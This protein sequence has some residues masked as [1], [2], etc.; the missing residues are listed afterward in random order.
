MHP[1]ILTPAQRTS[2]A[3]S[4]LPEDMRVLLTDL[5]EE[6]GARVPPTLP[7]RVAPL[8][9]F[10]AAPLV[11]THGDSRDA[12]YVSAM[13]GQALPPLIATSGMLLDGRHRLAAMRASGAATAE[14]IDLTGLIPVPVVP[15][16]GAIAEDVTQTPQFR[17]WFGQSKVLDAE[18]KPLVVHHGTPALFEAFDFSKAGDKAHW[19]VADREHAASFGT[20]QAYYLSIANPLEISQ[21]DLDRMWDLENDPE[22]DDSEDW[23][24][25]RHYVIHFVEQA[26]KD[27][28]DGLLIRSMEDR[29]GEFDMYLAFEPEQIKSAT[30]NRGDFDP[31]DPR[32]AFKRAA[33]V[34][35][36]DEEEALCTPKF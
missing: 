26:R 7:L 21:A 20:P 12:A 30:R 25:P 2:I 31:A 5:I 8:S 6:G 13:Q 24:L 10:P 18:G 17:A 14:Y 9:A 3:F 32:V 11:H 36:E 16:I 35:E 15:C 1:T 23:I 22:A 19:F 34:V 27:G 29:E 28:H 4:A 33:P